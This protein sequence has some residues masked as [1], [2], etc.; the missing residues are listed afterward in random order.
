MSGLNHHLATCNI[1]PSSICACNTDKIED[2][3]HYFWICPRYSDQRAVMITELTLLEIIPPSFNPVTETCRNIQA[4][5]SLIT[6]G[7]ATKSTPTNRTLLTITEN[8]I[9]STKRFF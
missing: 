5:T 9:I 6:N 2:A 1:I 7:D 8:Y 4:L 3:D